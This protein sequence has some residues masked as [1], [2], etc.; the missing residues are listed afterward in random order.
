MSAQPIPVSVPKPFMKT[1]SLKQINDKLALEPLPET[2]GVG[3]KIAQNTD[4]EKAILATSM[5]SA[6]AREIIIGRAKKEHFHLEPHRF[7]FAAV[8][9]LHRTHLP[10]DDI[11]I[12]GWLTERRYLD[13]MGGADFVIRLG[14]TEAPAEAINVNAHLD[15]L[16][17]AWTIR[18]AGNIGYR[19]A[20]AAYT[21]VGD[22]TAWITASASQLGALA[23][24]RRT[25]HAEHSST[26]AQRVMANVL[27]A[28]AKGVRAKGI[29]TG[30]A[31]I[32]AHL[33]GLIEG[34]V[35]YIA[36]RPG[37]GKTSLTRCI[38]LNVAL[39]EANKDEQIGVLFIQ[40]EGSKED[41][42]GGMLCADARVDS[43]NFASG[44]LHEGQ[45]RSLSESASR[46]SGNLI[47]VEDKASGV[48]DIIAIIRQAK[49]EFDRPADEENCAVRIGVI[50]I[51][52]VQRI[53]PDN[54]NDKRT[55]ALGRISRRLI[56]DVAKPLGVHIIAIAAMNR[57][58]EKRK[59]GEPQLSDIRDCGDLESDA[60]AVIFLDRAD[61]PADKRGGDNSTD[62]TVIRGTFAKNRHGPS[63]VTFNL[64]FHGASRSFTD[65]FEDGR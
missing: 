3:L 2:N 62:P 26:I 22:P 21:D 8:D 5:R 61:G 36:A 10:V 35:T 50:I 41:V 46:I 14:T 42:I 30:Y 59:G 64:R 19:M 49:A 63:G 1:R 29:A 6:E 27:D 48:D 25:H 60:D 18:E 15:I 38:A 24:Q 16:I 12:I 65:V 53:K 51:D 13:K 32:D 58:V 39:S 44:M 17:A 23:D 9:A 7:L 56:D 20:N 4:V 11:A 52:Y 40:L 34:R 55:E 43:Q 31:G 37:G 57:E 45:W 33:G 47:L 28:A 54:A